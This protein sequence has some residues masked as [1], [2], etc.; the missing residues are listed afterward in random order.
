M[1][2]FVIPWMTWLSRMAGGGP[3]KLP[4]GL[5]AWLLCAPYLLFYP[6][7]GWWV[8]PAYLIAV[9]G[10]RLGHGR[11]F[12]YN[13]PFKIGSTP[14]KVEWLID[15]SLPVKTQKILIMFLTG[16]AV[17]L[18]LGFIL[19][20]YGHILA[21][22]IIYSSGMLKAVAYFLPRTDWA[23]LVRGFFL[24]LGVVLAYMVI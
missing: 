9:L 1:I 7:I 17:T 21:G 4:Y 19:N 6:F 11:G 10:I 5:D 3:P 8:I 2:W 13:E 16:F 24:G 23:E 14:E 22:L 20:I 15:D 18:T 12:T